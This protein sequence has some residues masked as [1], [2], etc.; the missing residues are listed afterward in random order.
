MQDI[1]ALCK[2]AQDDGDEYEFHVNDT[3]GGIMLHATY[4]EKDIITN[5]L[6][7]QHTRHWRLTPSMTKS[8]IVQ[9]VFKLC[10]TSAEHRCREHFLYRS[11]RVFGPHFDVDAL[12]SICGKLDYRQDPSQS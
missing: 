5:K 1:V 2:Y 8:E 10:L 3:H 4:V 7:T 12:H 11:K 6:E 9:T